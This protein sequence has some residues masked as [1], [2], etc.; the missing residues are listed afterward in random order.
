MNRIAL[1]AFLALV[2]LPAPALAHAHLQSTK[3]ASGATVNVAPRQLVLTFS[4]APALAMSALRLFGPDSTP[5]ALGELTHDAGVRTLSANIAGPLVAGRYTVQWQ[6]AGDDGHVQRGSYQFVIAA[7]AEGLAS[8]ALVAAQH[9]SLAHGSA[10]AGAA[11]S[12]TAL[13]DASSFDE[14]SVLYV[15]IRWAQFAALLLLIGAMSFR[16]WILP[17][18]GV[19]FAEPARQAL[20]AGAAAMGSWGAW[21]LAETAI[22]RLLAQSATL[23]GA[24]H[25]ADPVVLGPLVTRTLWGDAWLLE[26]VAAIVAIVAL[27]MARR[28]VTSV[29]PWRVATLAVIALA[30]VPALSGH[31][32]ATPQQ[33]PI[34]VVADTVHVLAAGA[35]LGGLAVM[36][37]VGLPVAA[38]E[39]SGGRTSAL[40]TMVNAFSPLAL[41]S[42]GLLVLTGIIAA[43]YHVASWWAFTTTEYGRT[44]LV[45][46]AVVVLLLA[47]AAYNWRRVRPSLATADAT[48]ARRLT[49]SGRTEV[50]LAIIVL[51][52]TAVL[53][54]LPTPVEALH[55]TPPG[56]SSAARS[57]SRL[58]TD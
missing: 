28:N 31:A 3:P 51:L 52:V 15:V 8:P 44:L 24:N 39:A 42:A 4:E 7:G 58:M 56:A 11:S 10:A 57:G 25:M 22:A 1:V 55:A 16:W 35:W 36:L 37:A 54:A 17:H 14:N 40:P 43:R 5:V 47:V 46:L 29:L 13:P 9:D 30:V 20:A 32:I 48:G 33:A 2:A 12:A 50:L 34:A 49:R 6:T 41:G 23:H 45:K 18:A 21:L 27:G 53:V 19:A 26:I 38:R